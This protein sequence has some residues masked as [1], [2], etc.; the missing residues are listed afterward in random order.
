MILNIGYPKYIYSGVTHEKEDIK[1]SYSDH[2]FD[3]HNLLNV[4]FVFTT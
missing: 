4:T 2:S 1:V 3:R